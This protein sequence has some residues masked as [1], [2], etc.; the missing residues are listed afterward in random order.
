MI[1]IPIRSKRINKNEDILEIFASSLKKNKLKT[2][3]I[4][5]FA[6]KI[7]SL[8]QGR[9][10]K[11]SS[12][13]PS[14]KAKKIAKKYSMEPEFAELVLREA[15]HIFGGVKKALLTIKNNIFIANAGID[16]S[17]APDGYAI[18]WPEKPF[19]TADFLRRKIEEKFDVKIGLIIVD[20][21]CTPLRL[22]TSGIALSFSGF[23][24]VSDE[25]GK[26][27]IFGKK[28]KITYKNIADSLATSASFVMGESNEKTPFVIIRDS[29]VKIKENKKTI[30]IK[31]K[32]CIFSPIYPKGLI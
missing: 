22:G 21:H 19:E 29:G 7:V 10:V 26:K 17:N 32:K 25:R 5:V 15:D 18:L 31:P 16:K 3:D 28:L 23:E 13:K 14:K 30:S 11:L 4:V 2:G 9:V 8:W 24:P 12:I 6:S 1:V 20:S 27:D